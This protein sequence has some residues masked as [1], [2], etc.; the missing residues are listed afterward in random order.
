MIECAWPGTRETSPETSLTARGAWR[1]DVRLTTK[2]RATAGSLANDGA[3]AASRK[4]QRN[5]PATPLLSQGSPL[6][7]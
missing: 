2:V 1:G 6:L 7:R 4:Q 3:L 5:V